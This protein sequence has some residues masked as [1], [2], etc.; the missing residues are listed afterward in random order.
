MS[1]W[2]SFEIA[3]IFCLQHSGYREIESE[4]YRRPFVA[5]IQWKQSNLKWTRIFTDEQLDLLQL[6]LLNLW[7]SNWVGILVAR[8]L[9][10][11]ENAEWSKWV[12]SIA[13]VE[14]S[15]TDMTESAQGRLCLWI[16]QQSLWFK[17]KSIKRI[18]VPSMF[19]RWSE[20]IKSLPF[21]VNNF[22]WV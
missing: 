7:Q 21:K 13:T 9:E 19:H 1:C 10:P 15:R 2:F 17:W 12:N 18:C 11:A 22:F 20:F 14:R 6:V 8:G 5:K 3:D 16:Y 4:S